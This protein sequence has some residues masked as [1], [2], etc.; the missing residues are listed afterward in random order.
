MN[1]QRIIALKDDVSE[2]G[3][4][5]SDERIAEALE[6]SLSTVLRTRRRLVDEGLDAALSRKAALEQVVADPAMA[7]YR[8]KRE[9][10]EIDRADFRDVA[11]AIIKDYFLRATEE[12]DSI[13]K[14]RG[15]F[16]DRGAT[17]FG[18]MVVNGRQRHGT[19]HITVH[20]RNLQV[21]QGDIYYSFNE[22]VGDNTANGNFNVSYQ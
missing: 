13:D 22:N 16:V 14:L 15:C 6:T 8:A 20:C 9:F 10:D 1:C 2:N 11:L 17:S 3:P 18:A 21:A 7:R 4:G 12:I 5:W 19:A